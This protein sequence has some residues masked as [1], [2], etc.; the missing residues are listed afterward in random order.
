[1]CEE[2]RGS[3]DYMALADNFKTIVL[4][5]VPQI[6]I[7]RRDLMRRFILLI[8]V[9]YYRER[10]VVIEAAVSLDELFNVPKK[11]ALIHDEEFAYHRTLS[12]LKEMQTKEYQQR[13]LN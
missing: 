1:M 11:A 8:D 6:T 9:L 3:S 2:A 13:S 5:N 10:H 7:E 4:R 12:R